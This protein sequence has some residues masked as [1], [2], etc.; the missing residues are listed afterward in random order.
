M[1]KTTCTD[2]RCKKHYG[3]KADGPGD[4]PVRVGWYHEYGESHHVPG[5]RHYE[6]ASHWGGIAFNTR[7]EAAAAGHP[8]AKCC[9]KLPVLGTNPGRW[10][11]EAPIEA[12]TND[13]DLPE[14]ARAEAKEIVAFAN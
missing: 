8:A 12:P 9:A 11:V 14:R 3:D 6:G 2:Q 4:R 13:K 5:C 1:P 7:K 10:S